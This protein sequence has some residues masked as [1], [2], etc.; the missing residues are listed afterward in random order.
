L[1]KAPIKAVTWPEI[2]KIGAHTKS[3]IIIDQKWAGDPSVLEKDEEGEYGYLG[4]VITW[5]DLKIGDH[6]NFR[7]FVHSLS[8]SNNRR[9]FI[10]VELQRHGHMHMPLEQQEADARLRLAY[11][12]GA[13]PSERAINS[14]LFR[15]LPSGQVLE[16]H[17]RE[18]DG[19]LKLLHQ[20]SNNVVSLSRGPAKP[21][22][23]RK[24][25]LHFSSSQKDA[26][27][28][29]KL[30]AIRSQSGT[31]RVAKRICDELGIE[32]S[33]LYTAVRVAR[34]KGWL[35]DGRKGKAG[36]TMTAEG[37]AF[38]AANQ[39][40]ERLEQITGMKLGK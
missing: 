27:L 3:G 15:E 2:E 5:H 18:I 37:E 9:D 36:G 22:G 31:T 35:S 32:T 20:V 12:S 25:K 21:K 29:A 13:W 39:G 16:D 23:E 14:S 28:L 10:S 34:S 19:Y 38:F 30:Y 8:R 4:H 33:V 24:E 1:A 40:P 6:G 7:I 17:V 26:I 11:A